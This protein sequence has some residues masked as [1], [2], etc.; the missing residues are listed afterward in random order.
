MSEAVV[1]ASS[2]D[3]SQLM[4]P[5]GAS[6]ERFEARS[7]FCR[8]DQRANPSSPEYSSKNA[9]FGVNLSELSD[10]ELEVY[11]KGSKDL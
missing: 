10:V 7:C 8:E 3:G 6:L 9:Y 1:A 5:P 2:N 11:D 4:L